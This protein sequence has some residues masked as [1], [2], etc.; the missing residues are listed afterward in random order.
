MIVDITLYAF[1]V[2]VSATQQRKIAEIRGSIVYRLIPLGL[3][4]Q[5]A[6]LA[7]IRGN[8][9][10]MLHDSSLSQTHRSAFAE[11]R[12]G[13]VYEIIGTVSHPRYR[14]IAEVRGMSVYK[15][16]SSIGMGRPR[17]VAEAQGEADAVRIGGAVAALMYA[18]WII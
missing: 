4:P 7:E 10:H 18:G 2:V 17:K 15:M 6:P 5:F 16:A 12:G 8:T 13:C 9:V 3:S 1:N 14:Q 11:I